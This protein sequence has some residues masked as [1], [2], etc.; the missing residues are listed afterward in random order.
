MCWMTRFLIIFALFCGVSCG[1]ERSLNS[2]VSETE[3][4]PPTFT[5]IRRRIIEPKCISCHESFVSHKELLSGY[6][7]PGQP[8]ASEFLLEVESEAMPPYGAKLIDA[9]VNAIRTWIANGASYE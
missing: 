1:A 6:V 7:V 4:Y 5:E 3:A 2:G 8:D 9:E